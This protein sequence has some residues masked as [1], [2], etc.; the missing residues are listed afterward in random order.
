MIDIYMLVGEY[1]KALDVF[2]KNVKLLKHD[3]EMKARI[4]KLKKKSKIMEKIKQK[5]DTFL[6]NS[7]RITSSWVDS[8]CAIINSS[9]ATRILDKNFL[10]TFRQNNYTAKKQ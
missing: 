5:F 4:L 1:E 8:V 6:S 9:W 7:F 2:S 3:T 10:I